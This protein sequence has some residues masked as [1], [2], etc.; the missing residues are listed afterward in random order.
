MFDEVIRKFV[1]DEDTLCDMVRELDLREAQ[2]VFAE[3]TARMV[4]AKTTDPQLCRRA[5]QPTNGCSHCSSR[6]G[7]R[8]TSYSSGHIGARRR[9]SAPTTAGRVSARGGCCAMN[10]TRLEDAGKVFLA[11]PRDPAPLLDL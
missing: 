9:G 6:A 11:I 4:S 8:A 10:G 7:L 1:S 3:V 5:W 2:T